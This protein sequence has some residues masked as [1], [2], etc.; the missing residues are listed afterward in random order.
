[1]ENYVLVIISLAQISF[2][3]LVPRPVSVH[4]FITQLLRIPH[5]LLD[6]MKYALSMHSFIALFYRQAEHFFYGIRYKYV[7]SETKQLSVQVSCLSNCT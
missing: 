3:L 2:W 6:G 4:G 7:Q 5:Y 1:M